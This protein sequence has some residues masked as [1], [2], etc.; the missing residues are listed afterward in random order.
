MALPDE[1]PSETASDRASMRLPHDRVVG[2]G[3]ERCGT[4]LERDVDRRDRTWRLV[5]AFFERHLFRRPI[6]DE[7]HDERRPPNDAVSCGATRSYCAINAACRAGESQVPNL[8]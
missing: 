5:Q 6:A 8:L 3:C 4:V 7:S 2:D 1:A